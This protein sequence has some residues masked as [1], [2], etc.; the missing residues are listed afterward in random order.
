[1]IPCDVTACRRDYKRT[2][3][4]SQ[5]EWCVDRLGTSLESLFGV[6]SSVR[7][8]VH[9]TTWTHNFTKI[10]S[11]LDKVRFS[12]TEKLKAFTGRS[13]I[14]ANKPKNIAINTTILKMFRRG[15]ALPNRK[16]TR[17]SYKQKLYI[18]SVFMKGE[19][20]GVNSSPENTEKEMRQQIDPTGRK[21]VQP[22][23]YM[24]SSQIRNLFSKM[25]TLHKGGTLKLPSPD[26]EHVDD[27]N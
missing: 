2:V 6:L 25:P 18:Y 8:K 7:A 13:P 11:T 5:K 4:G 3:L 26:Q 24:A 14:A 1:M 17:F 27:I 10:N 19:Q 20:S 21:L 9:L 16:I 22:S 12:Y 15:W 23:E